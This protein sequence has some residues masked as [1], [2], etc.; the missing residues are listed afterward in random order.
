MPVWAIVLLAGYVAGAVSLRV[1]L[2][3][4]PDVRNVVSDRLS[5]SLLIA[6]L[7]W[8]LA[9][10]VTDTSVVL[11]KPIYLLYA[12]GGGLSILVGGVAGLAFYFVA[13]RRLRAEGE[14]KKWLRGSATFL[15]AGVTAVAA[16]S[17]IAEATSIRGDSSGMK[18]E[19]AL[20]D[21]AGAPGALSNYDGEWVIVKFWATW[22]PPC[23]A[24]AR[25]LSDYDAQ[26][27][28][29]DPV[30]ISVDQ[31]GSE[32]SLEALSDFVEEHSIEF[33]VF[34]DPDNR[35]FS[36]FGVRGIPTT[37]VI[38]PEGNVIDKRVGV[39]TGAWLRRQRDRT[40]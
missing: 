38:S 36:Q 5:T 28:P 34:L 19:F 33:R 29:G 26:R 39:V 17:A 9:P 40:R 4:E 24:E 30:L 31:T 35:V 25:L 7:G 12:T 32:R 37:F 18:T 27:Q 16:G 2:A 21:L 6:F 20:T 3:G 11:E 1:V 10:L 15:L 23:R 13:T 8:K 22:C 14:T